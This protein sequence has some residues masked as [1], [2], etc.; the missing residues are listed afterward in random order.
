MTGKSLHNR[1]K[2]HCKRGH[3]FVG[4]N[5]YRDTKGF[6]R[7]RT[8]E[9]ERDQRRAGTDPAP[10][11][12]PDTPDRTVESPLGTTP[13]TL[14]QLLDLFGVVRDEWEVV[15]F[16]CNAYPQAQKG[17]DG[18]VVLVQLY[19]SKAVLRRKVDALAVRELWDGMLADLRAEAA[20]SRAAGP[21]VRYKAPDD[22]LGEI[23]LPDLHFG[24]LAWGE[25]TGSGNY[26]M[27]IADERA[28]AVFAN[29]LT[30][31]ARERPAALVLPVGDDF[32][33]VANASGTT[34]RGTRQDVDSRL[35]K[36]FRR[37]AA[38]VRWMVARGLEVA[39]VRVVFIRGNHDGDLL[40]TLG[41]AIGAGYDGHAHVTVDNGP[42]ARKYLRW[43]TVLLG[44]THGDKEDPKR[45]PLTMA[46]ERPADWAATTHR[47][48]HLAHQHRKRGL[49][50]EEY[51]G[52]RV[53][54]LPTLSS[55]DA[56]HAENAFVGAIRA[57]EA[58]HW[59]RAH[60]YMGHLSAMAPV[61]VEKAA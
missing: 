55:E 6:R 17:P 22:L 39:P 26:D 18:E 11:P 20:A 23:R 29:L 61:E 59:S 34:V 41:E 5:V 47:E 27:D 30:R 33:H 28:R 2:T 1:D 13:I 38:F 54:W 3:A 21:R 14:D 60:G 9:R 35:P 51:A 58:Y 44:W 57:A 48:W 40:W 19:Q 36:M 4:D 56:W 8:C 24:K 53:R 16:T 43:G 7:C 31:T 25:E 50:D 49:T 32:F 12:P 46:Q 37:G 45:L 15:S 52:V 42:A 10:P